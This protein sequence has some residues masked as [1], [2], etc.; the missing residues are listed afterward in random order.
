MTRIAGLLLIGLV[1]GP[2]AKANEPT[3]PQAAPV[4]LPGGKGGIG[5]DDLGFAPALGKVLAPAGR[6]GA[7]ALIDPQTHA[8]RMIEGVSREA[9]RFRGGHGEGT[10][11]ADE[12]RGLLFAT[13]RDEKRL[14]VIDPVA[15]KVVAM[16][17]L[18]G[19]PDY[20]RWSPSTGEVWVTEPNAEQIEVFSVPL[21]GVPTPTRVSVFKVAGGPESLV[22]DPVAGR[23]FT[24]LW[25]ES[26]VAFDLLTKAKVGEWKNGCKDSRGIALD[27]KAHLLFAG[28][29]EGKAT[30]MDLKRD[31]AI[32]STVMVGAGVDVIA[33]SQTLH[34]LY[35]PGGDAATMAIV[36]VT[37]DGT[38][39][40]LAT[41]PTAKDAHCVAA[42]D[43]DQA[44]VCDPKQGRLLV[45]KDSLPQATRAP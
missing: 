11:S 25:K 8:V 14:V 19:G 24:H 28:C 40:V 41:V 39:S 38:L 1:A 33:Y 32:V 15:G 45:Y 3:P 34:H 6:T 2:G 17:A 44:W 20:M 26:T 29:D 21:K 9:A 16:A 42:D 18:A 12:G 30:S 37:A 5:F 35:V 22:I 13:D 10:T 31:G 43:H 4:P 7:L 36:G 27:P 23:A